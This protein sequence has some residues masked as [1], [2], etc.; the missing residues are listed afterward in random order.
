LGKSD[1]FMAIIDE[2][3]KKIL[4]HQGKG[5]KLAC[6]KALKG[7]DTLSKNRSLLYF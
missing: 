5:R 7:L 4:F 6:P 1:G 3:P 2:N